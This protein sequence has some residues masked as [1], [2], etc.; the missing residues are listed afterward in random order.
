MATTLHCNKP[1]ES[2]ELTGLNR[3]KPRST[4][5]PYPTRSMAQHCERELSP[6]FSL[7]NGEWKFKL[8]D[9][10]EELEQSALA[11]DFNDSE[12]RTITVPG[13]W[14]MQDTG[15]YPQYT[16]VQMPFTLSHQLCQSITQQVCIE[17]V[18]TSVMNGRYDAR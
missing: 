14:T 1:W 3:L 7:L 2:P 5:Y 15:D 12:W 16:N 17:P 13:C 4:L 10:P 11:A 8:F 9:R 18:L 6:W